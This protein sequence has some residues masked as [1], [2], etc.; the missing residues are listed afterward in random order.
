[1]PATSDRV[2]ASTAGVESTTDI[3]VF[4]GLFVRALTPDATLAAALRAVGYDPAKPQ[5]RYP[6]R[7]WRDALDAARRH[8]YP[9]LPAEEA[10]RLLGRTFVDGFFNTIAGRFMAVAMPLI[11][12]AAVIKRLPRY[13]A[14]VR[15]GV[16]IDVRQEGEQTFRITYRDTN[17]APDFYAGIIEGAGP[18]TK[19]DNRVEIPVRGNDGFEL[20]VTFTL[21]SQR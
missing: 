18:Y 6:T 3:S 19:S 7:V 21:H 2:E 15:T 16:T 9:K 11:G 14:A 17:P 12:P 4:E 10:L 8:L 13:W 20:V 5:I 1:M